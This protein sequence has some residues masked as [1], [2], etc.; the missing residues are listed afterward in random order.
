MTALH[1][2]CLSS[3]AADLEQGLLPGSRSQFAVSEAHL[4][5][6][7]F[8][9]PRGFGFQRSSF[10]FKAYG[11]H[12][13]QAFLAFALSPMRH[14]LYYIFFF[15]FLNFAFQLLFRGTILNSVTSWVDPKTIWRTY[16]EK[17]T[18]MFC[19]RNDFMSFFLKFLER[20][21][22]A[23]ATQLT[24][25]KERFSEAERNLHLTAFQNEK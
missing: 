5:N 20:K 11:P 17:T 6:I 2:S 25:T 23:A 9:F 7:L 4:F 10:S 13:G 24:G 22:P 21:L 18:T 12:L 1:F 19:C 15:F 8:L 14:R 3:T 16:E